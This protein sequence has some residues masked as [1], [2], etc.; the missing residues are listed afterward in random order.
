MKNMGIVIPAHNEEKRIEPTIVSYSQFFEKL[1][2]LGLLK[3]EILIVINGTT[4]G[5]EKIVKKYSSKNKNIKYLNLVRGG[6]GYAVI[7][8]FK[9]Y[10]ERNFD[11]IGFVDGDLATSPEEYYEIIKEAEITDGA[12]ADRYL[13]KSV[14]SPKPSVKRL[15][16][17]RTFNFLIR[18]LLLIPFGDTQCGAKVFKKRALGAVIQKLNMSQWA[19]DVELL[20]NLHKRGFDIKRI[21]TKWRDKEYSKINFW[22]A[23]PWMALGV[24]RLRILNSPLRRFVKI[25]DK[26]VRF[27]PK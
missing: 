18:S 1:E 5:T 12:I 3:Y 17:R 19:F 16:A 6:K 9:Y 26:F 23:G 8:G 24:V 13:P 20:Y 22:K 7:E 15:V 14:I 2:K 21:P 11:L 10:L 27:M 4:D 25:Y